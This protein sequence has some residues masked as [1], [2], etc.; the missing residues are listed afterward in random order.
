MSEQ[1]DTLAQWL[2][3]RFA[4]KRNDFSSWEELDNDDRSYWEHEAAAVRRAVAR[5]GFKRPDTQR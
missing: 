2:H 1:K 4:A 3:W 5:G